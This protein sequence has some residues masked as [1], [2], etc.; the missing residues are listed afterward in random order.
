MQK[1]IIK[2]SLLLITIFWAIPAKAVCPACTIAVASGLGLSRYFG[3]DDTVI[4]VWVGS[5]LMSMT[6]WTINWLNSKKIKFYGRK[7]LITIFYYG[8]TIWPLYTMD[9]IGHSANKIL[10]IDKLVFGTILGT[11][12]FMV[13]N[14]VYQYIKNKNNGRAHFPFQKIAI[15]VGTLASTSLILY[16]VTL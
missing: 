16:F 12:L 15:P 5:F 4:G 8:L 1:K 3:I 10:G 13:A 7:I 11:I 6:L 2:I 14:S 9:I